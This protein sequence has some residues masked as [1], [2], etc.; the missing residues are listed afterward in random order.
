M[1]VVLLTMYRCSYYHEH[2][3]TCH[4]NFVQGHAFPGCNLNWYTMS[5]SSSVGFNPMPMVSS[6]L[7]MN[8]A[9]FIDSLVFFFRSVVSESLHICKAI[10]YFYI[11]TTLL[12][13]ETSAESVRKNLVYKN[14]LMHNTNSCKTHTF[15]IQTALNSLL[16]LAEK[17]SETSAESVKNVL[18]WPAIF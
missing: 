15:A 6:V 7:L 9:G 10:V 3:Y 11:A 5:P 2:H 13:S 1:I 17:V 8:W 16:K 18:V 12:V 4:R 14:K